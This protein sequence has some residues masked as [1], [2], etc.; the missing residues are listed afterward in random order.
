LQCDF[1]IASDTAKF[2]Q[3]EI[4]LGVIPGIGG[5]QRMT[6]AVGK[7]KAM[8]LILTGRMMD[9]AEAE[10]AGLVA[11]LVPAASLMD[12]AMKVAETIAAMSLPAVVAAKE[13]VN[14]AFETPLA[15]GI[16]FERRLF[17]A[18]FS[19]RDRAEGMAA[20]IEKRPPKFEN[21]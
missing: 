16:R 5:T 21:R 8:D 11:R 18:L 1:I 4:R 19:T 12:E 20:F 14:R 10:R 17:H 3:P 6:R 13:A 2:G 9:A 15:E 7:A